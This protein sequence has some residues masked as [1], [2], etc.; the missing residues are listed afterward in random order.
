MIRFLS[1]LLWLANSDMGSC[2]NRERAYA[3]K[4]RILRRWAR[5]VGD[6]FQYIKRECYG[7]DGTG[8][9]SSFEECHRCNGT[10]IY[11]TKW[12]RLERWDLG[13]RIFHRPTGRIMSR[14]VPDGANIIRGVIR[15][16]SVDSIVANEALLWLAFIFDLGLW[17][18]LM[19][20]SRRMDGL[21]RPMTGLQA[22]VWIVRHRWQ[23]TVQHPRCFSCRERF[24]RFGKPSHPY[25]PTCLARQNALAFDAD[26]DLPF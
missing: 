16:E 17:W 23:D 24:W 11:D 10:G 14:D 19:T 13:G 20:T 21:W 3:I 25:C 18:H 9:Y 22:L 8:E 12:I 15:H 4:E 5:L 7:C 2:G 6:D 1:W 26:D